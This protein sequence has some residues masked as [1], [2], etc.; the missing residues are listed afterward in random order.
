MC[1]V[2]ITFGCSSSGCPTGSGSGSV[3]SRPAPGHLTGVEGDE[4][5]VLVDQP[6]A[7]AVDD[8]DAG[9]HRGQRGGVDHVTG[10]GDGGSVQR[11]DVGFGEESIELDEFAAV[12][13]GEIRVVGHDAH[14]ERPG[15]RADAAGDPAVTHQP[16]QRAV[17]FQ[18]GASRRPRQALAGTLGLRGQVLDDGEHQHQRVLGGRHRRGVGRVAHDHPGSRGRGNI[19][20]VVADADP[21]DDLQRRAQGEGLGVPGT[22][23]AGQHGMGGAEVAVVGSDGDRPALDEVAIRIGQ[24]VIEEQNR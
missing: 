10:V 18:R 2:T 22:L 19:D 15:G 6:A 23:G 9:L 16:Q 14:A 11:D 20:V 12:G 8:V 13:F 21:G 7:G 1:G 24:R 4:E 17:E 5:R 3:T